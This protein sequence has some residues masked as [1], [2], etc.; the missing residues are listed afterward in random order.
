LDFTVPEH[1]TAIVE[2]SGDAIISEDLEGR[3]LSWNRGAE[4]LFGYSAWE[5]VGRGMSVL[6]PPDRAD[7]EQRELQRI[8]CGEAIEPFDTVRLHRDGQTVQVSVSAF[9]LRDPTGVVIGAAKIARDIRQRVVAEAELRTAHQRLLA[10]VGVSR[11]L[12]EAP[13]A[14]DVW[15]RTVQF[16]DQALAADA[17]AVWQR[18]DEH[19]WRMVYAR[20]V[21]RAFSERMVVESRTSLRADTVLVRPL[22]VS[23]VAESTLPPELVEAYNSEKIRAMVVF[24][25]MLHGEPRGTLVFYYRRPRSFSDVE[26]DTGQALA[27]LAATALLSAEARERQRE[28][29]SRADYAAHQAQFMSEI[30]RV[31][32]ESLDVQQTLATVAAMA[33]PDIADWCTVDLVGDDGSVQRLA[34]AHVDP[35]K[36]ELARR[37]REEY[38]SNPNAEYSV[39]HVIRTGRP[40]MMKRIPVSLLE[41]A[42]RDASQI[43]VIRSL[44]LTSF[45]CVPIATRTGVAG[46]ITFVTAESQREYTDEDL[47]FATDVAARASLAIENARAYAA[48]NEAARQKDEFLA[49]LSHELRT[50]L[51]AVMGYTRML[52][53]G[54]VR[55]ERRARSLEAI[56]RNA[57]ALRRLVEEVLDVARITSGKLRITLDGVDPGGALRDAVAA[58]SPAAQAKGVNLHTSIDEGVWVRGDRDRLQQVFWNVVQNAVKFTPAG[59]DVHVELRARGDS[60]IVRIADTGEGINPDQLPHVFQRFHQARGTLVREH[61]GLGLGLAIVKDLIELHGGSVRAESAGPGCGAA[62]TITLP[63]LPASPGPAADPEESGDQ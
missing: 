9:P 42:A 22:V 3:I 56:E 41:G 62:F 13:D 39:H 55:P 43:D 7:E 5:M 31:L 1:L 49:T 44:S 24:P 38:P 33:C 59:G 18:D 57:E 29:A 30:T 20:G 21:S 19:Q 48:A 15:R 35:G 25:L 8:A 2:S 63:A 46:A 6:I 60:V 26:L 52:R 58:V 17:Y 16:A 47:R 14:A 50:P 51:N 28:A 40:A 34:V 32:S 61:G 11:L 10:L 23:T 37:L 27:N 36:V 54:E 45:M 4:R 12:I 53:T